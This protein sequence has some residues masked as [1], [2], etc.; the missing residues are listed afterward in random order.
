MKKVNFVLISLLCFKCSF[1]QLPQLGKS[2]NAAIIKAMTLSEKARL[3]MGLG[4][5]VPAFAEDKLPPDTLNIQNPI[6]G[7]AGITYAIPRL[8]IPAIIL[9]DGPAGVRINP[10]RPN[11]PNTYYSTAFPIGTL[12]A[13]TWNV[14]IIKKVG[15]ALG[16]EAKERGVDIF[17]G[18][19]MNTHRNVLGGRNFEYFSE[20]PL[21]SAKT[22][23]AYI[24]GLQQNNVGVSLKHFAANNHEA[25]RMKIDVQMG[26]R[27]LREIYL[28]GFETAVE[29]SKPWTIMSSYNKINGTYTSQSKPLITTILQTEWNYK[30]LV[31]TDWFAGDDG[32]AQMNAGNQ[33]IMPGTKMQ[34]QQ[35]IAAVKNGT[36]KEADL[37]KNVERILELIQRTNT[38]KKYK[39]TNKPNLAANATT[40]KEA[41][42]EGMV[43]LKNEEK[44]LPLTDTKISVALLGNSVYKTIKGGTG[45]GDVTTAY[46][47]SIAAGM[48]KNYNISKTIKGEYDKYFFAEQAKIPQDRPWYMPAILIP[49]KPITVIEANEYAVKNDMAL[50]CLGRTSGEFFDRKMENDYELS[51]TEMANIKSLSEAFHAKNKKLI[52]VLNI[53]GVIEMAS[54]QKYADAILLAWQPGQE[55]GYA[56]AAVLSGK[57]N[58]SGK[59]ATT[60]PVA[61]KDQSTAEGFPGVPDSLP[62]AITYKEGIYIGYR[63]FEKFKVPVLYEFGFGL[64]YTNFTY[65]NIKQSA[66]IFSDK[67]TVTVDVTNTGSVAGK[68]VVQCYLSAPANTLD[69]PLKELRGFAKTALLAPSQKQTVSFTINK[70]D[71]C[72]FDEKQS[73][74]VAEAGVYK[75]YIGSSSKTINLTTSFT[76]SKTMIVK[77]VNDVLAPATTI[78]DLK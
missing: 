71:L 6:E 42:T 73:A 38:F 20:D 53:G 58:P 62:T 7:A 2:S 17:L 26:Q 11:D 8:G 3:V 66:S 23:A 29:E 9:S 34:Y 54:W 63:Y 49:E 31:M 27:T 65:S 41:A 1:A 45:S 36:L 48:A 4:L 78:T 56:V 50:F 40:A 16:N 37:D 5:K 33:M 12:L 25:N 72:S 70:R 21:V 30:G 74:W 22:A 57:V 28:K 47:V 18:P 35:I 46:I 15:S 24:N 61:Y 19:A 32:A 52:V 13:S 55:A 51:L 69:K 60:F 77:K 39:F 44:T 64:S 67:I 76:L 10:T 59:L 14:E 43:L 75:V 68:E